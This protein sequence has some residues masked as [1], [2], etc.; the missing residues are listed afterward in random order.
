MAA[1]MQSL[2][3]SPLADRYRLD[4][5]VTYSTPRR[6][7]RVLVFVRALAALTRFCLGPG[8]RIVHVHTTVRGSLHRKSVC[9]ALAKVLRRPV[10]LHV[11]S[12]VGD[13]A[14]FA[15]RIGPI[16]HKL[17]A[18]A[19]AAADRVLSVSAAGAVEVQRRF[20]RAGIEVVP[21][22]APVVVIG[23]PDFDGDGPRPDAVE[24]LY[25]GGFANPVKGWSVLLEALPQI[26]AGPGEAPRVV[27][28]G[29]GDPPAGSEAILAAPGVR[30]AGWLD[31]DQ[32]ARALR[33]SEIFILPST[34][35]GLPVALLEAMAYGR[36][37]VAS[38]AGGVPEVVTD[39]VDAVMVPPGDATRLADAVCA[40]AADPIRRAQLGRAARERAA[41]LNEEEVSG[42]LDDIYRELAPGGR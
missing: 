38:R 1:V 20:G 16:R 10:I 35:E 31:T 22:P 41:R 21:N 34:S 6:L 27:L 8:A 26:A 28:A 12:G 36:A 9:V 2:L 15:E 7:A 5:I 37:I 25:L 42:R 23:G 33:R 17:F 4:V 32:K 24:A 14:A 40:L 39:G 30:W 29:P 13:L 19:F 3:V 18:G 11:H